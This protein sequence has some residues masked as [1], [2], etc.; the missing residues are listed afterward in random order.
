MGRLL[1]SSCG[2][3][4]YA[5]RPSF[6]S[7]VSILCWQDRIQSHIQL[8]LCL[9]RSIW[10]G[11]NLYVRVS[12][13]VCSLVYKQAGKL[14]RTVWLSTVINFTVVVWNKFVSPCYGIKTIPSVWQHCYVCCLCCLFWTSNIFF[15]LT[16]L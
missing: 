14:W 6:C 13:M 10:R 2:R 1:K 15:Y 5:P 3:V 4:L 7:L 12:L 11:N 9:I 8:S 16:W